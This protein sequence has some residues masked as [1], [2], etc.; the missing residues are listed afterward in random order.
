[1]P[2]NMIIR[3]G[4]DSSDFQKKMQQA[5]VISAATGAKI[6]NALAAQGF[7]GVRAF[8]SEMESARKAILN[9][10]EG[11]D[12]SKPLSEQIQQAMSARNKIATEQARISKR[13]KETEVMPV[14]N[15]ELAVA[16][17][18][19]K[20]RLLNEE[21]S[22]LQ[23]AYTS[24]SN[25]LESL[26]NAANSIGPEFLRFASHTGLQQLEAE[27]NAV[28]EALE[29]VG[30]KT[31]RSAPSVSKIAGALK[32]TLLW[33]LRLHPI[34]AII[35]RLGDQSDSS[36]E[37]M[38][39]MVQTIRNISVVS[40]GMKIVNALFGEMESI[41][42]EYINQNSEL[43]AQVDGLKS[44]LGQSLAPAIHLVT[45]ALSYILPYVVGVSNAIGQL[46]GALFGTGWSAATNG[47]NKMASATGGAAKA[48][49]EMN[50]QLLSFDQINK[51]SSQSDASSGG[52]GG[53]AAIA[54]IEAKTPAW[55]E[56]L[57]ATFTELFES[58]EFQAAN[59]GGKIG[60]ILNTS[61][62]EAASALANVDFSGA[63]SVLAANLNSMIGAID[64]STEAW[65]WWHFLLSLSVLSRPQTGRLWLRLFPNF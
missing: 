19:A 11:M 39:K 42:G 31:G 9:V 47:A 13:L 25:A 10:T 58:A 43:Q 40:F 34:S 48:Q 32:Q 5:G 53:G 59:T 46:M 24:A 27:I 33:G 12:L 52:G 63:G 1:M 36:S 3:L 61:I 60:M 7:S 21:L 37:R 49:K 28:N 62:G 23:N 64:W 8:V 30:D 38:E 45:N 15:T 22:D 17:Q 56:R 4:A 51:L 6:K 54:P 20:I 14:A 29:S 2:R 50:K 26:Q 44:S 55:A 57:K 41:V 65:P 35:R 16:R 18:Q